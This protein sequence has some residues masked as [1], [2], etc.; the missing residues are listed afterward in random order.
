MAPST[1]ANWSWNWRIW[2]VYASQGRI[3]SRDCQ[4][5]CGGAAARSRRAVQVSTS[6]P[7]GLPGSRWRTAIRTASDR[8][9][10]AAGGAQDGGR[11]ARPGP[12]GHG[13]CSVRSA[14]K[15]REARKLRR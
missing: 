6:H 13:E 10:L 14:L 2:A 4:Y 5:R 7:S 15:T 3:P 1:C 8:P 11:C 9:G 12:Y